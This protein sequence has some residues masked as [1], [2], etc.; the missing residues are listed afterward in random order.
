VSQPVHLDEI[1]G[2]IHSVWTR[3]PLHIPRYLKL[4]IVDFFPAISSAIHPAISPHQPEF[5]DEKISPGSSFW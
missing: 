1:E 4:K 2:P 5:S 3:L